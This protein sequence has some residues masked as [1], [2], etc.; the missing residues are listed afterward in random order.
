MKRKRRRRIRTSPNLT[1]YVV[2]DFLRDGES[3]FVAYPKRFIAE[4]AEPAQA[5]ALAFNNFVNLSVEV[6]ATFRKA[7]KKIAK[8]AERPLAINSLSTALDGKTLVRG[9]VYRGHLW[10][11]IDDLTQNWKRMF[12]WVSEEGL[13]IEVLTPKQLRSKVKL[14]RL[15]PF[16]RLAGRLFQGAMVQNRV[17]DQ[18]VL[19]IARQLDDV[20]FELKPHLQPADWGKIAQYNQ[21]YARKAIR[22]F[23]QAIQY[24]PR[25]IRR[26]LSDAKR[27]Y[28]KACEI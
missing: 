8:G 23:E 4:L 1:E 27:R 13:S 7:V 24:H 5:S 28:E 2:R 17:S 26:C 21:K 22:T 3:E 18:A 16:E 19:S 6:Q 20:G 9:G 12:W 10:K 15:T 14:K 25:G 11:M